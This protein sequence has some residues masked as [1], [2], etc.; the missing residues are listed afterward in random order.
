MTMTT[1]RPMSATGALRARN[2]IRKLHARGC[3]AAIRPCYNP[4]ENICIETIVRDENGEWRPVLTF[5][6]QDALNNGHTLNLDAIF[7]KIDKIDNMNKINT[8]DH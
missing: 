8:P 7:A 3:V 6:E 5:E 2:L 1:I 4:R